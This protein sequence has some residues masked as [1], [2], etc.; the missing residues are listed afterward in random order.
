LSNETINEIR[1][2]IT[3]LDQEIG[4]FVRSEPGAE[5]ACNLLV[6]INF[7]KRDLSIVYDSLSAAMPKLMGRIQKLSLPD[8]SEIEQ[9]SAYERKGWQHKELGSAVADRLNQLAVDP[10]TG[11][12][13]KSA[14]EIAVEMLDYCAPSYWRIKELN[15]I[16]IDPDNYCEVG[17]LRTSIIV[18]KPK[19]Q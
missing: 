19:N 17:E 15:K 2:L 14:Y 11:E 8:G 4:E 5:E 10:D 7:L 16:G 6:D 18:R 12:K 1:Q 13:L 9:K 3:K